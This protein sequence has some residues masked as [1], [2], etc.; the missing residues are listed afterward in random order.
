MQKEKENRGQI[1][2]GFRSVLSHP[3]IYDSFQNLMGA[4]SGRRDF[5]KNFVRAYPG[6]RLLDLGCGTAQ[7]L[8]YLPEGVDYWGYDI[9]PE[10]IAAAQ[11]KFGEKGCFA[12]RLLRES[13]LSGMLPFDIVLASGLLHHMDDDTARNVFRLARLA[14]KP[15]GRFVSID[16]VF[17]ADQNPIAR[18]LVSR[19]RG[20]NVRDAK[21]YLALARHEFPR[22]E[23]MVRH[24]VWIPYTHLIMECIRE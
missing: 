20:Q 18:F 14:L 24:R 8:E 16:S 7:I 9:N 5:S 10:Y 3:W 4:R 21:G 13:D 12:C 23:S 19:D 2:T 6:C 17:A 11:A 15:G 1:T 22:V